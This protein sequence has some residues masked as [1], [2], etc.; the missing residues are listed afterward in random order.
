VTTGTR[1]ID[2][3][4]LRRDL[5]S[6]ADLLFRECWGDPRNPHAIR[7]RP[8]RRKT[9]DDPRRMVMQGPQRGLWY[10]SRTGQGGDLFDFLAIERLGL[11][12]ARMDF[13]RVLEEAGQWLG[14]APVLPVPVS[15]EPCAPHDQDVEAE[16]RAVLAIAE[17]LSGRPLRYWSETRRLDL[18]PPDTILRLPGVAL[19]RRP[20]GSLLPFAKR[21][22][23][24][25]LGRDV[26]GTVCA[27]QRIILV[28]GGIE[29]DPTL[30]K[31]ALGPI[32]LYPPF[33]PARSRDVARGILI[34]AEGPE[35]AGA[36]W[37]ATG[38]RVL[39]CGGSIAR[40]LRTLSPL[41]TVIVAV[42]SDAPENAASRALTRAVA[43]ARANGA[44]I[45]VLNCGGAPGSGFDAADLIREEGGRAEIRARVARLADRLH[46]Q[47]R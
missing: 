39:V 16:L 43:E 22:A 41:A 9:G 36:I 5:I 7:W 37:S 40:R 18:P 19:A 11:D 38:A 30:P 45:G 29:R 17:P 12:A 23:V 32:G 24:V 31:F 46:L 26:R 15:D 21:E 20:K 3:D 44:R 13:C 10:D 8:A 6:R 27:I 35:T 1:S 47:L 4:A 25:V 28:R 14:T 42:E 2:L 33:F 34:L